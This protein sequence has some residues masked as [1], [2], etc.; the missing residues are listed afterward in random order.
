MKK[1]RLASGFIRELD[2]DDICSIPIDLIK[3]ISE[4]INLLDKWDRYNTNL[5]CLQICNK[6]LRIDGDSITK[7]SYNCVQ[8]KTRKDCKWHHSFGTDIICRG[9]RKKWAL[10]LK[11]GKGSPYSYMVSMIGIIDDR[12][13][14]KNIKDFTNCDVFG[15]GLSTANKNVYHQDE[16]HQ[17]HHL[18][19]YTFSKLNFVQIELDLA[20]NNKKGG[21]LSF[22]IDGIDNKCSKIAF[23]NV[24]L[25]RN[26]RLA[27][28][29]YHQDEIL[30]VD[31]YC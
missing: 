5:K 12:Y 27:V 25:N 7:E 14:N 22:S 26:Y 23:N 9:E 11:K 17:F 21:I 2:D 6:Y 13:V 20:T 15:Y 31:S 10:C 29:L 18:G 16:S 30:I 3:F 4:W 19:E 1:E 24:D 8:R 28:A